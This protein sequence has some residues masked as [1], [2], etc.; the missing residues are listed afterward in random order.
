MITCHLVDL[1]QGPAPVH[2]LTLPATPREGELIQL[3]DF[4]F[5]VHKVTHTQIENVWVAV[6]SVAPDRQRI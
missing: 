5:K 2:T 1:T 3:P 4:R 6:L